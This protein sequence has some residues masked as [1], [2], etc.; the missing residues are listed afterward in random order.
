MCF[1]VI[2]ESI[3]DPE[4]PEDDTGCSANAGLHQQISLTPQTVRG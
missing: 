4:I 3:S 1:Q 2:D